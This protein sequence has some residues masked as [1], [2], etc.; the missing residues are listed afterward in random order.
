MAVTIN[1]ANRYVN[2]GSAASLDDLAVGGTLT[3]WAWV[4]RTAVGAN[5][6]IVSKSGTFPAG[7]SFLQDLYSGDGNLRF[8]VFRGSNFGDATDFISTSGTLPLNRWKFVAF[9]FDDAATPEV[10]LY[11]G[12]RQTPIRETS[13][14][15]QSNGGAAAS[16]DA[17]WNLLTGNNAADPSAHYFRGH[18]ARVGV[19]NRVLSVA[20]LQQIQFAS[21]ITDAY[22]PG[23]V[24]LADY[25]TDG[26]FFNDWSGRGNTGIPTAVTRTSLDLP[27]VRPVHSF[28]LFDPNAV[29]AFQ[30]FWAVRQPTAITP[31]AGAL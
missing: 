21:V 31:I 15:Q 17:S 19:A 25:N 5:Q 8:I 28:V 12:D 10:H 1:G 6:V 22:H 18:I 13:Y 26:T 20:E 9:T 14:Y 27:L 30:P 2:H 16:T 3:G 29:A 24:L 23:T 11:I 7:W 4:Y